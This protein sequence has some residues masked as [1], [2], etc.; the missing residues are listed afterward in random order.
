MFILGHDVNF[1]YGVLFALYG[2]DV[3]DITS[4]IQFL[5]L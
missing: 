5:V 1:S 3:L 2:L 4:L